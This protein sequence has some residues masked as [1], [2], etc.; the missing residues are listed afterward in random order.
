[1]YLQKDLLSD[2][3]GVLSIFKE[4]MNETQKNIDVTE[5]R[6]LSIKITAERELKK[7]RYKNYI[8]AKNTIHDALARRLRPK[9]KDIKHF[10]HLLEQ[11]V[12]SESSKLKYILLSQVT[13]KDQIEEIKEIFKWLLNSMFID[14]YLTIK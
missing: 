13:R 12:N 6:I 11:W 2:V 5:L 10:D 14:I 1:M 8:S 4:I 9:I 7:G 3:L